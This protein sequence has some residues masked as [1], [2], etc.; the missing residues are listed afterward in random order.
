M[1]FCLII[2][3]LAVEMSHENTSEIFRFRSQTRKKSVISF[4]NCVY[5]VARLPQRLK[6][7]FFEFFSRVAPKEPEE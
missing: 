1:A 3:E 7:S 5:V 2:G 6:S 4:Q